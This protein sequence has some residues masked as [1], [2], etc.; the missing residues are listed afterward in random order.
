MAA[1]TAVMTAAV[2]TTALSMMTPPHQQPLEE[3]HGTTLSS[4]SDG[5]Q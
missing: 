2:M 3:P 1:L 5:F 4:G